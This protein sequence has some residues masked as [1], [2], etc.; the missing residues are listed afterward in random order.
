MGTRK[1]ARPALLQ[2]A[3][4]SCPGKLQSAPRDGEPYRRSGADVAGVEAPGEADLAGA[5]DDGAAVSEDC[6]LV[7]R[8]A[9]PDQVRAVANRS[10]GRQTAGE[11]RQ[12]E[13]DGRPRADL[14][15]VATA[16]GGRL[17]PGRPL[18]ERE[19]A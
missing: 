7:G 14:N 1:P 8:D 19:L 9:E 11:I 13:V 6:Q 10:D 5:L 15:R 17:L 12:V 16:E 18:Q 4:L 3:V 2:L